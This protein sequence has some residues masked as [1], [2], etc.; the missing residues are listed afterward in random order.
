MKCV[1]IIK[2]Q[3]LA[4]GK[5]NPCRLQIANLCWCYISASVLLNLG[6]FGGKSLLITSRKGGKQNCTVP[7]LNLESNLQCPHLQWEKKNDYVHLNYVHLFLNS[8]WLNSQLVVCCECSG[9]INRWQIIFKWKEQV[10]FDLCFLPPWIMAPQRSSPSNS[11]N[12]WIPRNLIW[13]KALC[14]CD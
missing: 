10:Y 5:A 9:G 4:T 6:Q 14:R 8:R 13:Q 7:S 11:P 2:E 12:L 1:L 3:M